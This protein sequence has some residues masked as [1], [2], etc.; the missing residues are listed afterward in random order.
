[1]S[2]TIPRRLRPI[3]FYPSPHLPSLRHPNR[4]LPNLLLH[5]IVLSRKFL[6]KNSEV[7]FKDNASKNKRITRLR[8]MREIFLTPTKKLIDPNKNNS[9][10]I[11][12]KIRFL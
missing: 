7:T 3:Y 11:F 2:F 4:R 5:S 8:I 12:L 1:M 9:F 10:L 6:M